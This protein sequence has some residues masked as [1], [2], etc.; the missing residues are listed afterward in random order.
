MAG[1]APYLL[2]IVIPDAPLA[3]DGATM[4]RLSPT[5][6]NGTEGDDSCAGK[7]QRGVGGDERDS[8]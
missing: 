1:G 4:G 6:D 7:E 3:G 5:L 2:R 8:G